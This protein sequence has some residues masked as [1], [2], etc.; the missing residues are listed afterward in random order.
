MHEAFGAYGRNNLFCR[1]FAFTKQILG[2]VFGIFCLILPHIPHVFQFVQTNKPKNM[3]LMREYEDKVFKGFHLFRIVIRGG[4]P[5]NMRQAFKNMRMIL[6][7]LGSGRG[8]VA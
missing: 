5:K 2:G 7:F 4:A 8:L 6:M 1:D 3:R